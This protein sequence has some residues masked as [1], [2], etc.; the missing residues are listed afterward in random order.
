MRAH[1]HEVIQTAGG[2]RDGREEERGRGADRQR[3]S[4]VV[5]VVPC[6]FCCWH[7]LSVCETAA[8]LPDPSGGG[9][10]NTIQLNDGT[11]ISPYSFRGV[12]PI[13]THIEVARYRLLPP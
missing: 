6:W 4:R 5:F 7:F 10:G 3:L 1:T 13:H 9:Y 11:L 2:G 8:G 12:D